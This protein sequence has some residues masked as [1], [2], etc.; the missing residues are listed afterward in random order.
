MNSPIKLL[1]AEDELNLSYVL[2]KE[3]ARQG[4]VV[5][6]ANHGDEAI[7]MARQKE[8]HVAL[9]D[10]MMPGANG[11]QVLRALCEQEPSP[12]VIIMT[13]HATVNT[14]LE[15]MKLGAYDYL[16]KPCSLA[17][18]TEVIRKAYEKN[19]LKRENLVLQSLVKQTTP[20]SEFARAGQHG[21]ITQNE[22]IYTVLSQIELVAPHHAPVLISGEAGTGKELVARAIHA[23]S[24]RR[25]KPFVAL[26]CATVPDAAMEAELFGYEAGAMA[27]ARTRKLGLLELAHGG[28]LLLEEIGCLSLMAQSRLQR[29][30]ENMTFYR[31]G[32]TRKLEVDVRIIA[33]SSQNLPL[34][35]QQ[36]AFRHDFYQRLNSVRITLPSLR[37]RSE[38][39]L[40]LAEHFMQVLAPNRALVFSPDARRLLLSY[41]WPGNVQELRNVI[42]RAVLLTRNNLIQPQDLLVELTAQEAYPPRSEAG[43][44]YDSLTLGMDHGL[45]RVNGSVQTAATV[46]TPVTRLEETERHAILTALER[47]NWHQ[48][49]TADL[50]GISPSTLYRRLREYKITKRMMRAQRSVR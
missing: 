20:Q 19:R 13:G 10:L 40:P 29:A 7:R 32:G 17:E 44:N 1:I 15:A 26:N 11:I 43:S 41:G 18:L 47:T 2:Q 3:L 24:P 14:A 48:G 27:T 34:A 25:N 46:N 6:I 28:T 33:S 9:L 36:G 21:I 5:T 31:I 38:D 39:I 42:E 16:T 45:G 22:R 35:A 23:A 49:K 12:E 30:L 37:E 8:F 4:F 50:L